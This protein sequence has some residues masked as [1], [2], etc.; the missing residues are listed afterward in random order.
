[1]GVEEQVGEKGIGDEKI[2]E[3]GSEESGCSIWE[4]GR[5]KG[6]GDMKRGWKERSKELSERGRQEG[7]GMLGRKEDGKEG[8]REGE[9][10]EE[11]WVVGEAGAE[12]RDDKAH[13]S[14]RKVHD[15]DVGDESSGDVNPA[16][17][18]VGGERDSQHLPAAHQ[19]HPHP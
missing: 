6:V 4:G 13:S 10:R 15:G 14:A 2:R 8:G 17:R 11:G 12:G 5:W 9:G 19:A 3:V 18:D 16:K 7:G 1:M